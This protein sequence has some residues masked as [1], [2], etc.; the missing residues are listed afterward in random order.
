MYTCLSQEYRQPSKIQIHLKAKN[1][2]SLARYKYMY[3]N[4]GN[5]AKYKYV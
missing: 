2:G 4:T 1:A 3:K 5:L